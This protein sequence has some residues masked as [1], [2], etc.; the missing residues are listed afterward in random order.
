MKSRSESGSSTLFLATF[1]VPVFFFL[2]GLSLDMTLYYLQKRNAQAFIDEAVVFAQRYLPYQ[3][4]A[5]SSL[6]AFLEKHPAL[7][8]HLDVEVTADTV[9]LSGLVPAKLIF[10]AY[11]GYTQDIPY[12][13]FSRAQS[14]PTDALVLLDVGDYMAPDYPVGTPWGDSFSWPEAQFFSGIFPILYNSGSGPQPIDARL[15]TQQCFNQAF[16]PLKLAAIETTNFLSSFSLNAVGVSVFPGNSP[17]I[18][19][20]TAV[21]VAPEAGSQS[22]TTFSPYVS[23]YMQSSYCAKAAEYEVNTPGYQFPESQSALT[24][25]WTPQSGAPVSMVSAE[26]YDYDPAYDPYLTPGEAIWSRAARKGEIGD[27]SDILNAVTTKLLSAAPVERRGGLVHRASKAAFVLFGDLPH[28]GASSRY[29][30][31]ASSAALSLGLQQMAAYAAQYEK[32]MHLNLIF[33][34]HGASPANYANEVASLKSFVD[35]Q[36]AALNQAPKRLFVNVVYAASR[37]DLSDNIMPV[38]IKQ[39]GSAVVVN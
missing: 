21:S 16:S 22:N 19:D 36:I 12:S 5:R 17:F 29:P 33:M 27:I 38:L 6:I 37:A 25:L 28:E 14:R 30:A 26:N 32:D 15:V 3:E 23:Q 11:F 9:A 18:S 24:G 2:G 7:F 13:I 35:S 1:V 4:A 34:Q 8:A 39:F 10:P 31:L 20:L